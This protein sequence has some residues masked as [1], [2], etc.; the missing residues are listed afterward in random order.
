[1]AREEDL[2]RIGW[3]KVHQDVF[4][5]GGHYDRERLIEVGICPDCDFWIEKWRM[6]DDS[7]VVRVDGQHYIIGAG[8]AIGIGHGGDTFVIKF[9]D[10][11]EMTTTNLWH[12]GEIPLFWCQLLPDNATFVS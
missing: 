12:Q 3:C 7:N 11:R 6:R 10:G 5:P 1:M 9:N 2:S 8:N 4:E